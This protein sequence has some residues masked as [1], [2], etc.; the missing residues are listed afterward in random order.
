MS[1]GVLLFTPKTR[2]HRFLYINLLCK[3]LLH[4]MNELVDPHQTYPSNLA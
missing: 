3:Y 2:P 1:L 4:G